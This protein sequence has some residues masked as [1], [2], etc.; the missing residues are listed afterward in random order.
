MHVPL[1][2]ERGYHLTLPHADKPLRK[3]LLNVPD[4]FVILPMSNGG[5]RL[6]G[7]V[8]LAKPSAKPDYRRSYILLEKAESIIGKINK[9]EMSAWMG[10]RPSVPETVPVIG[11][12]SKTNGLYLATGHGHLGLTL[13]GTT[14][15]LLHDLI[16]FEKN[17]PAFLHP[18]RYSNSY[19]K[20]GHM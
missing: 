14:A 13:A 20:E 8:E 3:F 19:S 9:K 17:P 16:L 11:A 10:S 7:T 18:E 12:S 5:I 4:S 15:K 1:V 6:A 2:C